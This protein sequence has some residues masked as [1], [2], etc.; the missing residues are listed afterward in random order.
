MA[1]LLTGCQSGSSGLQLGGTQ[2][3]KRP[4]PL[5]DFEAREAQTEERLKTL[6]ETTPIHHG[7]NV[8]EEANTRSSRASTTY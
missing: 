7:R 5:Y 1:A 8:R 4:D 6:R 2:Q 3:G